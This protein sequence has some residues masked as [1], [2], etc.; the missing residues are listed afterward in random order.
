[1]SQEERVTDDQV[2]E[3]LKSHPDAAANVLNDDLSVQA[4]TITLAKAKAEAK[5]LVAELFESWLQLKHIVNQHGPTVQKR[6]RKKNK[7]QRKRLLL[8]AWPRTPG[9]HRPDI[10][11][12]AQRDSAEEGSVVAYKDAM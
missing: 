1:M 3:V 10:A 6:W 9:S 7:E 5:A 2:A 8:K 4:H 11:Y 12:L